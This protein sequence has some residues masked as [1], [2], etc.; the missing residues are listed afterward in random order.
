LSEIISRDVIGQVEF[1]ELA[2]K[3]GLFADGAI[4]AI[5]EWSFEC[6]EEALLDNG[7]PIEIARHL[8]HVPQPQPSS[9]PLNA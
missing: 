8:F 9:L 4:E 7:E 5:N 3:H 1:A 6:F 2:R